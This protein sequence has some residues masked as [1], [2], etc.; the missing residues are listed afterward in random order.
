LVAPRAGADPSRPAPPDPRTVLAQARARAALADYADAADG[1]ERFATLSPNA[2]EAPEALEDA[3]L[4]RLGL[5]QEDRAAR[6]ADLFFQNYAATQ[7]ARARKV[8]LA[9]AERA[10]DQEDWAAL[11]KRLLSWMGTFEGTAPLDLRM[12]A[13]ALL[14][15]AFSRH[16][17]PQKAEPEYAQVRALWR[18]PTAAVRA[19]RDD[20]GDDRR[21][22][23]GLTTLGEAIFF[24]AEKK[25]TE[26]DALPFPTYRG[27]GTKDDIVKHVSTKVAD[28]MT[29]RRLAI[30]GAEQVY[31]EVVEIQPVPPP[32][33]V[34]ASAS[35]VGQMWARLV[36]EVRASP[37]PAEW[38]R[39][40]VLPGTNISAE[41]L[42]RLYYEAIDTASAPW[43][44]R[45]KAAFQ[46]CLSYA[47]KFQHWDAYSD[48]CAAWLTRNYATEYPRI[49]QLPPRSGMLGAATPHPDPLAERR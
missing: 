28:W 42:R 22:A 48:S 10:A 23:R 40:G 33:W 3:V 1:L 4:L 14:G 5:G 19:I 45:A 15:R 2:P 7:Q 47:V 44:A 49:D 16:G 30:E 9:L 11:E 13:H 34:I 32:V 29:R 21:L 39:P 8:A 43:K 36:A 24:F 31:R 12:R 46:T 37:I 41:D 6:D 38:R 35:R 25:R 18:D 17:Q 20:G 26:A 27:K